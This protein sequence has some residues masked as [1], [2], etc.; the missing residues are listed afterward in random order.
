LGLLRIALLNLEKSFSPFWI[1][2]LSSVS[3]KH[4][5]FFRRLDK[6]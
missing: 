2:M 3:L 5:K 6:L 1:G 4:S